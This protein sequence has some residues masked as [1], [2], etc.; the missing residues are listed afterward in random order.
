MERESFGEVPGDEV[1]SADTADGDVEVHDDEMSLIGESDADA[2]DVT[3]MI[4]FEYT[5]PT[6][7]A[8]VAAWRLVAL[9]P[10]TPPPR[11]RRITRIV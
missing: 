7:G 6:G 1:E 4:A 10:F 5:S 3:V 2:G 11:H 9:T 8:V